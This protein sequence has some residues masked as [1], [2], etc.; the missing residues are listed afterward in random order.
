MPHAVLAMWVP[1]DTQRAESKQAKRADRQHQNDVGV[2]LDESVASRMERK[3]E[4]MGGIYRHRE[5]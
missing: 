1:R 5:I 2:S 4:E 3:A